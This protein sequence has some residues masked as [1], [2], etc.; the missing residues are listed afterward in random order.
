MPNR[1]KGG[2]YVQPLTEAL[3]AAGV[4][5]LE[6]TA[7]LPA[8][9]AWGATHP[10][11]LSEAQFQEQLLDL[12]RMTGWRVHHETDSRRTEGGLPD[13][14]CVRPP[15]LVVLEL[16]SASGVLTEPQRAWLADCA[17][18]GI[19][20][21]VAGPGDLLVLS[22]VLGRPGVRL[23]AY[24]PGPTPT[25]SPEQAREHNQEVARRKRAQRLRGVSGR[26]KFYP[27]DP[28]LGPPT[29]RAL[30]PLE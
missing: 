11:E 23:P 29:G 15:R 27:D 22:K 18:C 9:M 25:L 19:E 12:L 10:T 3:A 2:R 16:K 14:V 13:L 8:P 5:V 30:R 1:R 17:S 28:L 4:N 24:D 20:A 6:A 26:G 7:G 21:A